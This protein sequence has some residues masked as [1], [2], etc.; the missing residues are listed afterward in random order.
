VLLVPFRVHLAQSGAERGMI[1][2][3]AALHRHVRHPALRDDE[4]KGFADVCHR[5]TANT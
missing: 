1:S 5:I 4:G 3:P 2:E